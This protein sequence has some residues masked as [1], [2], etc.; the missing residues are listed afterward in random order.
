MPRW[1]SPP[2]PARWRGAPRPD[3]Q[4]KARETKALAPRRGTGFAILLS[5]VLLCAGVPRVHAVDTNVV[6]G[7]LANVEGNS[8]AT[9]LFGNGFTR[10]QQVYSASEFAFLGGNTALVVGVSFRLDGPS[11][12]SFVNFYDGATLL[13]STSSRQPDGLSSI[14]SENTGADLT[15]LYVGPF[16]MGGNYHSE[17]QPQPFGSGPSLRVDV[18]FLYAP[19]RGNLLLEIRTTGGLEG[20]PVNFDAQDAAGDSVSTLYSFESGTGVGTPATVGLVTEFEWV[21]VPE[22]TPL[23]LLVATAILMA[24]VGRRRVL[25]ICREKENLRDFRDR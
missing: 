14:F 20:R 15:F 22:P 10:F 6:P 3:A 21:L 1:L 2:Q 9:N 23:A 19:S 7:A 5:A 12:Q 17:M 11:G 18:P 24:C 25:G 16:A 4:E 13:L 8:V